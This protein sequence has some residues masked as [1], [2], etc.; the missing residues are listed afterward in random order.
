MGTT[1][2]TQKKWIHSIASNPK[3]D[4]KANPTTI[5]MNLDKL[6]FYL[7][8]A[9]Y[10]VC[11]PSPALLAHWC[12]PSP[13]A[14]CSRSS[15][16]CTWSLFHRSSSASCIS[17]KAR[18]GIMKVVFDPRYLNNGEDTKTFPKKINHS[19]WDLIILILNHT[20][21]KF[22]NIGGKGLPIFLPAAG[23]SI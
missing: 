12:V 17:P 1:D 19:K 7:S 9:Y 4:R 10:I 23:Y 16:C 20:K 5:V 8:W 3:K 22:H 21:P 11:Q 14:L 18:I 6:L 15:A 2:M 13:R